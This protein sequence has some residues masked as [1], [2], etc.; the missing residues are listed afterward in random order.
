MNQSNCEKLNRRK[1][2]KILKVRLAEITSGTF[3]GP[4][5][6]RVRS[7]ELADDLQQEY[8]IN[9]RKSIEDVETR[10]KLHLKPFF[11]VMRAVD[12]VPGGGVEPPRAEARRI[13]S[14]L[15]LPVPPSRLIEA[16]KRKHIQ[17]STFCGCRFRAVRPISFLS[18]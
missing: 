9:G 5:A 6:E 15:R 4:Q 3:V 8:R 11:G 16:G 14:P 7:E 1:A 18:P 2:E 13:L 12:V 10:W 17:V